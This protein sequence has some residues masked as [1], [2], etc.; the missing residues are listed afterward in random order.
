MHARKM[1]IDN[2]KFLTE[3]ERDA[4]RKL[5][6]EEGLEDEI[7]VAVARSQEGVQSTPPLPNNTKSLR[8]QLTPRSC[9][10]G[11]PRRILRSS[12]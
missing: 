11:T 6:L 9:S 8:E 5:H 10:S 3:F 12:C 7:Q 1:K 2:G 4:K